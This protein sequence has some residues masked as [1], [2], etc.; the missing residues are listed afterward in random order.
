M[1][2]VRVYRAVLTGRFY[3]GATT[4]EG[5]P[6][7][8]KTG[9]SEPTGP[10]G[11]CLRLV[12]CA[13]M[14]S[15]VVFAS[16]L[17]D[18]LQGQPRGREAR[19]LRAA[20]AGDLSS[21]AELLNDGTAVDARGEQDLAT[22][23]MLAI[24]ARQVEMCRLLLAHGADPDVTALRGDSPLTRALRRT[25][26]DKREPIVRLLLDAGADPELHGDLDVPPL[27]CGVDVRP[28]ARRRVVARGGRR[29]E[30]SRRTVR[31]HAAAL[32]GKRWRR[33]ANWCRC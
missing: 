8:R 21:V 12:F 20:R 13:L 1:P 2:A 33:R 7:Y 9:K 4:N 29:C 15:G 6:M 18:A 23:L 27:N 16:P 14:I 31:C 10:L 19:L 25:A 5:T 32:R 17:V 24:D 26:S 30:P 11:P 22:P 28:D 3:R